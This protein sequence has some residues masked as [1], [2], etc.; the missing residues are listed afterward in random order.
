MKGNLQRRSGHDAGDHPPITPIRAATSNDFDHDTWRIY[1]FITRN[2]IG[3]LSP[4]AKYENLT[5]A[6]DIGMF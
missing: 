4:D 2:F 5:V 1:D 3:S 6:F